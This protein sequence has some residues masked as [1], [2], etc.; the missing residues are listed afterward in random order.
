[1]IHLVENK[2]EDSLKPGCE[3]ECKVNLVTIPQPIL[4]FKLPFLNV[5]SSRIQK[6]LAEYSISTFCSEQAQVS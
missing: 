2:K 6:N 5:Q 1:M 4:I 3:Q